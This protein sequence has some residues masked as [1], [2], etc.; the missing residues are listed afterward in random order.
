ME[1]IKRIKFWVDKSQKSV[2]RIFLKKSLLAQ[3]PH[4]LTALQIQ[5]ITDYICTPEKLKLRHGIGKNNQ[6]IS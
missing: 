1:F 2:N 4:F 5:Q 3:N 6:T